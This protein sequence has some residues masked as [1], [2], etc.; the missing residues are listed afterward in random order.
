MTKA[1]RRGWLDKIS[2]W[3]L[4]V[5][6]GESSQQ[7]DAPPAAPPREPEPKAA[8]PMVATPRPQPED[9]VAKAAPPKAP[10]RTTPQ[11]EPHAEAP[12]A[13]ASPQPELPAEKTLIKAW[14]AFDLAWKQAGLSPHYFLDTEDLISTLSVLDQ[15]FE[16][17]LIEW[18]YQLCTKRAALTDLAAI[19]ERG[20][21]RATDNVDAIRAF[22]YVSVAVVSR[23]VLQAPRQPEASSPLAQQ[24]AQTELTA[25]PE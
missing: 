13:S 19:I 18:L 17:E 8:A 11:A 20:Q 9:Q 25:K 3:I 23:P 22:A 16:E 6:P 4:D 5:F 21:V 7:P 10:G 24:P 1:N 15:T 12:S 14:R 2:R